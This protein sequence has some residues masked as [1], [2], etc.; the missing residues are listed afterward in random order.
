MFTL[1]NT[2]SYSTRQGEM[3]NRIKIKVQKSKC[4]I[5][6]RIRMDESKIK[7]ELEILDTSGCK[8]IFAF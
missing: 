3:T 2:R 5:I 7:Y 4:K 6:H 1:W 8:E